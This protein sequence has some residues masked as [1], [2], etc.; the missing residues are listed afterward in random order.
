MLSALFVFD[1]FCGDVGDNTFRHLHL[2]FTSFALLTIQVKFRLNRQLAAAYPL[3]SLL[4]EGFYLRL[5]LGNTNSMQF[6]IT[7]GRLVDDNNAYTT[8]SVLLQSNMHI[9]QF[10]L[11]KL[12]RRPF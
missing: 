9:A 1:Y 11:K 3:Q 6:L 7:T 10:S 5:F 4:T 12:L 2:V 8:G